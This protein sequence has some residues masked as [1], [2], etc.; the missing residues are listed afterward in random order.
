MLLELDRAAVRFR[1]GALGIEDVSLRVDAG[2]IIAL[3]GP[4]GAGK[5]TTVRAISGFMRAEGAKLVNGSV[6]FRDVDISNWE[7]DRVNRAGVF[8]VPERN[9]LFKNLSVEENLKAIGSMPRRADQAE[10]FDRVFELFPL[11][12][13]RRTSIAGRLSGGQQQML[14]LGRAWIARPE[15]LIIDEMTL[16]LH[17][18]LQPV[19]FDAVRHI[20]EQ[21]TAVILVEESTGLALELADYCYL[22]Y[23]GHVKDEGPAERFRGNELLAAGYLGGD[24]S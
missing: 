2:A 1:N 17:H 6:R 19:L 16:G 12:Y 24:A 18:S 9:K 15:L 7:P 22:L 14:A 21:G 10:A 20:A 23:G 5:T 11:L 3:V 8:Y 13:E 4:N